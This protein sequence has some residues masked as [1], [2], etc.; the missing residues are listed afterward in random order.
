MPIYEYKCKNCGSKFEILVYSD[1]KKA[2]CEK[3]GSDYAER[4]MSGFAASVSSFSQTSCGTS[5]GFT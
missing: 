2:I 5:G 1:Q 4:L 3:C